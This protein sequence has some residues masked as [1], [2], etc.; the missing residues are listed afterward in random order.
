MS[1][2]EL[3]SSLSLE[4]CFY[5]NQ[6]T[7]SFLC[8]ITL[9]YTRPWLRKGAVYEFRM[10]SQSLKNKLD[11]DWWATPE[12][13]TPRLVLDPNTSSLYQKLCSLNTSTGQCDFKS[14]VVLDEDIQCDGTCNARRALW[15]GIA[16]PCECSI[17]VP[18]TIR[19]DHS[20]T[21]APVWYEYVQEPCV[22]LTF[23]ESGSMN[24]VKEIGAYGYG[25]KAMCA[26]SRLPVAGTVCCDANGLNPRS[27]CIFRGERSTYSTA[28]ERCAAYGTG[29][30]TCAWDT[31]PIS[32]DCGTDT[33][34]GQGLVKLMLLCII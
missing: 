15:D 31:V 33:A 29:W 6:P 18:R 9:C 13:W 16:G 5:H 19:L 10:S 20:P 23:P 3:V 30:Q 11:P 8:V 28:E 14:T 17:D 34:Y 32:W 24:A 22:Q 21:S 1:R 25:N 2:K 4:F 7:K 26:D 27:I 12:S